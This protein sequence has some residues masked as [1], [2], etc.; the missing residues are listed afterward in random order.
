MTERP[1]PA[2]RLDLLFSASRIAHEAIFDLHRELASVGRDDERSR[3]LL[4]ESARI[5]LED[6]AAV[7][8]EA[9][10]LAEH[11][12]EQS[13][14]DP[15]RAAQTSRALEAELDRI[16]PQLR[17]LRARHRDVARILRSRVAEA[18]ER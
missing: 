7:T 3:D 4:A 6:L 2:R 8:V 11:W 9:R 5:A 18:R 1:E 13:L 17:R 15:A 14:L 12:E 16:G 10:R